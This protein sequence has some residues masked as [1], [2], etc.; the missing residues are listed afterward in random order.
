MK[1]ILLVAVAV[2]GLL[3]SSCQNE[4]SRKLN[5]VDSIRAISETMQ[6]RRNAEE[7]F[8]NH[9]ASPFKTEPAVSYGG[10]RWFPPD[11]G[12]Y[13]LS[14]LVKYDP[15]ETVIVYGTKNE[16]RNQIRYGY[17][18]IM[19]EGTEYHLNVYKFTGDYIRRHPELATN[20]SVWFTDQTTGDET[21]E[22]GRYVEIE[23]ENPDP[24]HDYVVNLN[25][26][27]NPY[28]AYNE[29]YSCAIPTKEDHLPIP[30]RAGELKYRTK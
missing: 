1:K 30:I 20:L 18:P 4:S 9:P 5:H 29:T 15:P 25:N 23:P 7:F 11:A 6:Y 17:F 24:E 3:V 8:R 12:Y 19:I 13:F 22:V 16:P 2:L 10:I 14:R 21:Y 26:S 28:C 27:H